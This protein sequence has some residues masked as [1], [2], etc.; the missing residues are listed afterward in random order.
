MLGN[1]CQKQARFA[2]QA[3]HTWPACDRVCIDDQYIKNW[4]AGLMVVLWLPTQGHSF[5]IMIVVSGC[6]VVVWEPYTVFKSNF[7]PKAQI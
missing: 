1:Q 4:G 5:G 2:L 3:R 7:G 6:Y